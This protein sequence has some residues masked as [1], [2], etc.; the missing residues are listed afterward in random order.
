MG[1]PAERAAGECAAELSDAGDQ[2][3]CRRQHQQIRVFQHRQVGTQAGEAEKHRHEQAADQP[4]QPLVDLPGQDRRFPDHDARNERAEHGMH[5][6]QMRDHR[7]HAHQEQDHGDDGSGADEMVVGPADQ[8]EGEPAA[9]RKTHRQEGE[10]AEQRLADGIDVERALRGEAEDDGDDDPADGVVDDGSRDNDLADVA[11][12]KIHFAHDHRHDLH[13]RDRKRGAEKQRCHEACFRM[14]QQV[15][16]QELAERKAAGKGHDDAGDRDGDRGPADLA[17][18]L[19]VGL[20][21]GQQQQQENTELRDAI[22]Q[23]LLRAGRRKDRG[24]CLRP[25]PAEQRGAQDQAAEQLADHGG[26]ADPL[27]QFAEPASDRDQQG[28]LDQQQEF[29]R[30]A[31]LLAVRVRNR[32]HQ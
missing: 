18:Q 19:E 14:R 2:H 25:E 21:A 13:R 31:G 16:R 27:H 29:R 8:P 9:D 15:L 22:E 30:P 5:A 11:A 28:Y 7:H 6:D 10:G 26:L 24:L 12:H 3:Q 20:H 23:G 17:H 32:D 4:A 1:E